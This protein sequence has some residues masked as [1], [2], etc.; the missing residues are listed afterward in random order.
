MVGDG[1]RL[2][3]IV[4]AAVFADRRRGCQLV[5]CRIVQAGNV[6]GGRA[7]KHV[8]MSLPGLLADLAP[9]FAQ[10]QQRNQVQNDPQ[11]HR[12][13]GNQTE[14]HRAHRGPLLG[15]LAG[16]CW[17][18]SKG[19]VARQYARG[20]RADEVEQPARDSKQ[21]LAAPA[22]PCVDHCAQ[23]KDSGDPDRDVA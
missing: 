11:R 16:K 22:W 7:A 4:V 13:S 23:D 2:A 19:E 9:Q 5:G 12:E 15:L 20:E 17:G 18:K 14:R 1:R 3:P 8:E 21:H 10:L 6:D